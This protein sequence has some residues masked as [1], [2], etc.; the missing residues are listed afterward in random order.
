MS[1]YYNLQVFEAAYL[2]LVLSKYMDQTAVMP[3]KL[4]ASSTLS[5]SF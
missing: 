3:E 2:S 1:A 4:S 5:I